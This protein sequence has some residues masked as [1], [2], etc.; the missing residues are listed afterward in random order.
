MGTSIQMIDQTYGHMARD[1]E[2]QDR[3]LLDRYDTAE[4]ARGHVV[5]TIADATKIDDDLENHEGPANARPSVQR[6]REDSNL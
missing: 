1:A 6:A 4:N 2:D 3:G 5:G